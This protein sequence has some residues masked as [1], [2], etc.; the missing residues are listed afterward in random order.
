MR[1]RRL[2]EWVAALLSAAAGIIHLRYAR[3]HLREDALHGL[4]FFVVGFLQL[5][6]TVLLITARR[7][8]AALF[9]PAIA[10]N[11]AVAAV[12]AQTR[13]VAVPFGA[14][15]GSR[16]PIGFADV[17]ASALEL[18]VIVALAPLVSRVR[19]AAFTERAVPARAAGA[20]L[21]A[22]AF[23]AAPLTAAAS[24]VGAADHAHDHDEEEVAAGDHQHAKHQS[25]DASPEHSAEHADETDHA[26]DEPV[27]L[28]EHAHTPVEAALHAAGTDHAHT[29]SSGTGGTTHENHV[30]PA[31][32]PGSPPHDD[33]HVIIVVPGEPPHDH[34]T[35]P[36]GPVVSLS[37]PRL[38]AA[39]RE[40]A[41][42]LLGATQTALGAFP[43]VAEVEAAGYQSIGDDVTG[44]VHYVNWNYLADGHEFD[45]TRIESIVAQIGPGGSRSIVSALYIMEVGKTMA[46]I[47]DIAGPLTQPYFHIH[48]NLC[49]DLT[50]HRLVGLAVNGVC[51][52]GVLLIT[53]P[54]IHVWQVERPCGPFDTVEGHGTDCGQHH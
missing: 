23:A 33:H 38:T 39:Q 4:F 42:L 11:A 1:S 14:G 37:D 53:P 32:P 22:V 44:F 25:H 30:D 26:H 12:W 34:T 6:L 41:M 21:L 49:F 45:P 46:D 5:G 29:V 54:M 15:A 31:A 17:T 24:F 16:E 40:A 50:T 10:G 35:D 27:A 52:A 19:L 9:W 43:T 51:P 36:T 18:G 20:A 2:L 8:P 13:F 7:R 47:P 3:T 28:L 48:T